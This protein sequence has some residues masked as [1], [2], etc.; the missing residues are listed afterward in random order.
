MHSTEAAIVTA[1]AGSS[2]ALT[3][4]IAVANCLSTP[5]PLRHGRR[6]YDA[7]AEESTVEGE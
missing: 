7:A 4:R 2:V 3:A 1:S 5:P 6:P